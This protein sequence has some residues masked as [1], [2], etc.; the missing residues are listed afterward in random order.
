HAVGLDEIV[1][2]QQAIAGFRC[3]FDHHITIYTM[4][5][6]AAVTVDDS[7]L[8][9]GLESRAHV[10]QKRNRFFDFVIGL[11]QQ[12]SRMPSVGSRGSSLLLRIALT[13]P[14]SS[15]CMRRPM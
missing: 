5:F 9:S 10:A 2:F 1:L 15:R 3:L 7:Y 13:L 6:A 8:G 12:H 11:E 4:I 14:N